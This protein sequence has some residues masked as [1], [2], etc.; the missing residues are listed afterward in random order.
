MSHLYK[1]DLPGDHGV[2]KVPGRDHSHHTDGLANEDHLLG[3]AGAL[4]NLVANI[5]IEKGQQNL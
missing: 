5:N 4:S 1:T 2:G 3:R